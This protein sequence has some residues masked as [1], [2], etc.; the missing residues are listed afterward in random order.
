M[1]SSTSTS[2]AVA[3]RPPS[4]GRS[5]TTAERD[6]HYDAID[7]L[8]TGLP[9]TP[10][11]VPGTAAATAATTP[12]TSTTPAATT[13]TKTPATV[14]DIPA[15]PGME[16]VRTGNELCVVFDLNGTLVV[17]TRHQ[18]PDIPEAEKKADHLAG[19]NRRWGTLY[20]RFRPHLDQL[21]D[22]LFNQLK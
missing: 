15:I 22:L 7:A 19:R 14:A 21:F 6:S 2:A 3:T 11:H 4:P 13:E 8:V 9:S 18:I 20:L 17:Y 1:A 12:A 5:A 16:I 10:A